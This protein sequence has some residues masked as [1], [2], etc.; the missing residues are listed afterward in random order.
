MPLIFKDG[1]V[2]IKTLGRPNDQELE[3]YPHVFFTS[4]DTWNLLSWIMSSAQKMNSPGHNFRIP[5]LSMIPFL[6]LKVTSTKGSA[7]LNTFLD[8]PHHNDISTCNINSTFWHSLPH[9]FL[10]SDV[11]WE[12]LKPYFGW[13]PIPSIQKTFKV[14]TRY[15]PAASTQ[16]Y[17]KKHFKARNPVFNIPRH[18]EAVATD[19]VFSDTPVIADGSTMAQ[20]FCGSETPWYVM[21]MASRAPSNSSTPWLIR[22]GIGEPCTPDGGSYEISKKVT[23]LLRSLFIADCQSEPYHQHQ[24]KAE[25]QWGTAKRWVNTIMNSSGC[26]PSA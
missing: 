18:N 2:C 24:N 16:D 9:H 22:S 21:H 12:A 1:L 6:M 7:T 25:N 19:T 17:L 11:D 20:F 26:P 3:T 14:T 13:A 4:P 10:P 23:D 15:G 8:L 5:G